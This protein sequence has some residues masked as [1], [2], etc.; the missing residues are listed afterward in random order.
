MKRY[1]VISIAVLAGLIMGLSFG[2]KADSS[3]T[4]V[5]DGQPAN[6]VDGAIFA[7]QSGYLHETTVTAKGVEAGPVYFR[8]S[9]MQ[10]T[11]DGKADF[12][13]FTTRQ[14]GVDTAANPALGVVVYFP[15]KGPEI[16]VK[17]WFNDGKDNIKDLGVYY[18]QSLNQGE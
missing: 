1:H 6:S 9:E 8:S 10:P 5:K 3:I 18:C 12:I 16:I 13:L 15:H 2:A 4:C 17:K 7:M 11:K 14:K